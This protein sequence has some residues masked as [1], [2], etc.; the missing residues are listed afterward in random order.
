MKPLV[1]YHGG[2]SWLADWIVD[3]MPPHRVYVEPFAGS[4]AVLLAKPRSTHEVLNDVDGAVVTFY[5]VLRE[6]PD[7]LEY[8]CRLTPYAR[9]EFANSAITEDLDD[10]EVARRWWIRTNQ[11][12]VHTGHEGTGWSTSVLRG[13][14][15]ARTVFNR[16]ERFAAVA[17]RL[18]HC[19]IENRDALYVIERYGTDD[20]VIY[21]D[22]PYLMTTRAGEGKRRPGGDYVHEFGT[23]DQHRDLADALH[24][25]SATV[26]LS[27]YHSPLYDDLYSGWHAIE[28]EV[29]RRASNGRSGSQNHVTEVIW[30]NRPLAEDLL[31]HLG[32][33]GA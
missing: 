30:S 17:E 10:L 20:G 25:T 31:T 32:E 1:P 19:T 27:G 21:A 15:N 7:E 23:E 18:L 22:P 28:R 13:S 9:D 16:I 29:L 24:A 3:L 4:A 26:L 6:R 33:V 12:F 2:K 8:A 14:N 11:S 5:R